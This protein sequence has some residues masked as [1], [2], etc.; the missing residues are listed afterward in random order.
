MVS[1][2]TVSL[3]RRH[4]G[5]VVLFTMFQKPRES[6]PEQL[7]GHGAAGL[8]RREGSP[9]VWRSVALFERGVDASPDRVRRT[10]AP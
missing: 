10:R 6:S 7:G 3:S 4:E 1:F 5:I 9:E 2:L 8:L